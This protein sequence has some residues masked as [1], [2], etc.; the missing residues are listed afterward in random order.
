MKT[1]WDGQ[2]SQSNP[3][4]GSRKSAS[5]SQAGGA[6]LILSLIQF[7]RESYPHQ[8]FSAPIGRVNQQYSTADRWYYGV[9]SDID[10]QTMMILLLETEQDFYE[11][12]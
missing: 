5:E 1:E 3:A 12:R 7:M 9:F 4:V 11:Q 8:M 2:L 10:G 6:Q